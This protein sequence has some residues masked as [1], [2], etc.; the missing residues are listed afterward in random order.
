MNNRILD[1]ADAPARLSAR[2]GRLHIESPDRPAVDIPFDHLAAIVCSHGQVSFTQAVLAELAAA[3][4]ILI[5][6]DARHLPVAMML[7][8]VAHHRQTTSFQRQ[9][10]APLPLRKRLWRDIVA[11]KVQ[12]QAR[13]LLDVQKLDAGLGAI[14]RRVRVSNASP[15]E[16]LAGRFY[17]AALF[18]EQRLRRSDDEDTRNAFLD[19]GYAIVRAI[20]ARAICAAGLH[21]GLALHHHNQDDP[22]PL[23][24]D[25][26]EPFRPL[27][28]LWTVRWCAS[29]PSPWSLD[30]TSKQDLLSWLTARYSDG[31]ES[32]SLF[33][34][35]GRSADQLARCLESKRSSLD[36]P[37]LRCALDSQEMARPKKDPQRVPRHV[38]LRDV[39]SAG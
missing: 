24:N 2:D 6:C 20:V 35:A 33:D 10:L 8:L 25:L 26:M 19:Y 22:Y 5:S 4:A 23:A 30:K 3:N 18:G 34:W 36:F 15:M 11:A 12:A 1:F 17:W 38:A 37:E 16:A 39:R 32:R 21:P 27:V 7:P 9:A 29:Q 28:D 14:A 13:T 31:V